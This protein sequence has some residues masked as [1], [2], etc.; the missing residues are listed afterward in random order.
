MDVQ[1]QQQFQQQQFQQQQQQQ[2]WHLQPPGQ[3]TPPQQWQPPGGV[4]PAA[5]E[6]EAAGR[7]AGPPASAGSSQLAGLVA[8]AEGDSC[9]C[10]HCGGVVA[11]ARFEVHIHSWC[12]A[13]HGS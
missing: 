12:P 1:Q 3:P 6:T 8:A 9:M 10:P 11:T 7:G 4:G 13:L 5:M 2:H